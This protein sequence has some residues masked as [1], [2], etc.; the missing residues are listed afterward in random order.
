MVVNVGEIPAVVVG[1][2]Q[3][4]LRM[5]HQRLPDR[6]DTGAGQKCDSD[7]AARVETENCR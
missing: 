6:V 5:R 3:H 1:R 2:I 7:R 4:L